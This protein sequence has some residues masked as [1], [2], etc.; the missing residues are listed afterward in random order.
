MINLV[1]HVHTP[2]TALDRNLSTPH[3]YC[4]QPKYP[5]DAA[6]Q[7]QHLFKHTS[8]SKMFHV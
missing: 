4:Q 8:D 3:N 2:Q 7:K 6:K 5:T 1:D